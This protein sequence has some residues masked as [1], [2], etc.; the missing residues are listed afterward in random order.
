M[1][2]GSEKSAIMR[3]FSR[4]HLFL[5]GLGLLTLATQV[6]VTRELLGNFGGSE[7]ILA[8]FY[9]AW[10]AGLGTGAY[11]G[12][13]T[14]PQ[15]RSIV[16]LALGLIFAVPMC[17]AA[18]RFMAILP[19]VQSGVIL[20]WWSISL[21]VM[22][23]VFPLAVIAGM[24]FPIATSFIRYS[25]SGTQSYG[26]SYM[27]EAAGSLCSGAI[28][29]FWLLDRSNSFLVLLPF[30]GAF[31]LGF[32]ILIRRA[33]LY[34]GMRIRFVLAV[35][36]IHAVIWPSLHPF[37]ETFV[38]E[39]RIGDIPLIWSGPS[40]YGYYQI[41]DQDGTTAVYLNGVPVTTCEP[42][43]LDE[44]HTE[45]FRLSAGPDPLTVISGNMR[46]AAA[47][48]SR[49][50]TARV[51]EQDEILLRLWN[52]FCHPIAGHVIQNDIRLWLSHTS[53]QFDLLVVDAPEPITA[54]AD[55]YYTKE[56]F[57]SVQERLSASGVFILS[58]H[59]PASHVS[60]VGIEMARI[61]Y[62]TL[63]SVFP[64]V[65]ISPGPGGWFL[66]SSDTNFTRKQLYDRAA[67]SDSSGILRAGLSMIFPVHATED[68]KQALED[69][70]GPLNT[71]SHPRAFASQLRV[72]LER[73]GFPPEFTS[74]FSRLLFATFILGLIIYSAGL[75]R[76]KNHEKRISLI[77]GHTG[78]VSF[79]TS[80]LLLIGF[81]HTAGTLYNRIALLTGLYMAGLT[82]GAFWGSKYP[83]SL[84]VI[85]HLL[86]A[87]L[88]V[89]A[90]LVPEHATPL[91]F[92]ILAFIFAGI[93]G[94][95]LPSGVTRFIRL[96]KRG[97]YS[98]GLLDS[99]DHI[100]AALGAA[101]AGIVLLP[102][103]GFRWAFILLGLT[104]ILS[105]CILG[106][107][108]TNDVQGRVL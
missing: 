29:S 80:F 79:A 108:R 71:D 44:I 40:K 21:P 34:S 59:L 67:P 19:G 89:M 23:I 4:P 42:D 56:F 86:T 12:R 78:F 22:G 11:L 47:F 10:L 25:E 14:R 30:I 43:P 51:I 46:Y 38:W 2:A 52:S 81:Q 75:Y 15:S 3:S 1:Y 62:G 31:S 41:A 60:G 85:D 63:I 17:V 7:L 45:V 16:P 54:Q 100:G 99:A 53:G 64:S 57:I 98:A 18:T 6:A 37:L 103:L 90:F 104:K 69:Q 36:L 95:Q 66:A 93:V 77:I 87:M 27:I 74:R 13:R 8:I 102:V 107:N 70:S 26:L 48:S 65:L 5:F 96:G 94:V 39:K 9:A 88:I 73:M 84:V 92:Y 28:L 105:V 61:V 76:K 32:L 83:V 35:S 97:S 58:A 72:A 49:D 68:F 106:L 20:P 24:L 33:G 55:R 91:I 101:I 82:T 50:T